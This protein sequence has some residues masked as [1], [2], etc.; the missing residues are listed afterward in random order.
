MREFISV[1]AGIVLFV[2]YIPYVRA[3]LRGETKPA[4]ASWIIWGSLDVITLV[5]MYLENALNGQICGATAGAFTVVFLAFRYGTPGWTR[6]D[7]FCLGGAAVGVLLWYAFDDPVLG[8]VTSQA[9]VL[10]ASFPTLEQSGA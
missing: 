1:L 8:I 2:G 9:V 10:L 4:K 3:I 7:R 5:G 6:L